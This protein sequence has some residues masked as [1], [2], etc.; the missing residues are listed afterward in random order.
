MPR[1][2]FA[3]PFLPHK[4]DEWRATAGEIPVRRATEHRQHLLERGIF[5]ERWWMQTGAGTPPLSLVLWDCDDLDRVGLSRIGTGNRH[6]DWMAEQVVGQIHGLDPEGSA[7]P[8]VHLL[9]GTT[10]M[11]TATAGSQTMF[12]LPIPTEGID[13]VR[14]LVERIEHGDLSRAHGQFLADA[15]IREEWIWLQEP[16]SNCPALLLIH[17]IGDDLDDAWQR[18]TYVR[19]DPYARVLHEALFTRL[20][21]I[22]PEQ[23]AHW[24]I[25]QLL[26][27]H[28]RR[29]DS[30]TPSHRRIGQKLVGAVRTGGWPIVQRLLADDVVL[31]E[32]DG[33]RHVGPPAVVEALRR[34]MAAAAGTR[35]ERPDIADLLVGNTHVQAL[36]EWPDGPVLPVL[37]E[38]EGSAVVTLYVQ[39][40]MARRDRA[41]TD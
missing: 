25:E 12:A 3:V 11:A 14:S 1:F 18:L 20:I 28:V 34:T 23:V 24:R 26:V 37:V 8:E 19:D 31:L 22:G 17:W 15:S 30:F 33:T 32:G 38:L 40:P 27:M 16:T 41:V 5:K 39:P 4:Q 29:S 35:T 6:D 2:A 36:L 13:A 10:T 7:L 21:G 9:S